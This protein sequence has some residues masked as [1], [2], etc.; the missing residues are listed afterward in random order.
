MFSSRIEKVSLLVKKTINILKGTFSK[1]KNV[2]GTLFNLANF[3]EQ[4]PRPF[5]KHVKQYNLSFHLD[6]K[7]F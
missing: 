1:C 5:G 4:V 6:L 7:N 3:F 2:I